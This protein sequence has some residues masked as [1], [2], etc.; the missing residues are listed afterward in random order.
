MKLTQLI[1]PKKTFK[2]SIIKMADK[3][4]A[5]D[6]DEIIKKLNS[7]L[8]RDLSKCDNDLSQLDETTFT[9]KYLTAVGFWDNKEA[10]Y[11]Y[12]RKYPKLLKLL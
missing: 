9:H 11:L 10:Q 5:G 4:K 1:H 3:M 6:K 7:Q 12:C 8:E 2:N